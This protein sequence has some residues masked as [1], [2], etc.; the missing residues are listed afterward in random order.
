ML[1]FLKMFGEGLTLKMILDA[2][3]E[4]GNKSISLGTHHYVQ[5]S[6][7]KEL[8]EYDSDKLAN[9]ELLMPAGAAVPASCE[10]GWKAK[11]RNLKT[12][13]NGYGQ[14]EAGILTLNN[15]VHALGYVLPGVQLKVYIDN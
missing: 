1:P 14:T 11:C 9:L 5:L 2:T 15:N 3:A 8:E 7:S 12:V 10:I 13:I 4:S 6:E